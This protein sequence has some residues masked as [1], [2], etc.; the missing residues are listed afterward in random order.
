M[1]VFA[2]LDENNIVINVIVADQ[3]FIDALPNASEYVLLTGDAGI[4]WTYDAAT[5]EFI[6]PYIPPRPPV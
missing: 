2:D 6:P 5:Q 3:K 4:G 1:T